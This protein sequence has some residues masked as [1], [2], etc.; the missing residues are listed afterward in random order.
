[1]HES[2]TYQ[3]IL[4]EGE[5]RGRARSGARAEANGVRKI[6]LTWARSDSVRHPHRLLPLWKSIELPEELIQIALRIMEVESWS[7]L[8]GEADASFVMSM[9][10]IA[11]SQQPKI[12][13][14][15]WVDLTVKDCPDI[16]DFY[17]AVVGWRASRW[18]WRATRISA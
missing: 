11:M 3:M 2:D 9:G 8:L 10:A 18:T 13:T 12:G 14:I 17:K 4:E 1:M 15:G 7:E 6:L 16:R 5:A